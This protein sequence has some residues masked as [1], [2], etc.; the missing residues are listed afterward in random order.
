MAGRSLH[1][2]LIRVQPSMTDA[3][4]P[5]GVCTYLVALERF[6]VKSRREKLLSFYSFSV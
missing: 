2:L 3:R 1:K 4:L 5:D 6:N